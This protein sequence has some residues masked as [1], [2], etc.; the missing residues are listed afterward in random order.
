MNEYEQLASNLNN[1]AKTNVATGTE[2][3]TIAARRGL[4]D[5]NQGIRLH[6]MDR[7][8]L[9]K[10]LMDL[11]QSQQD[12]K[13]QKA[14]PYDYFGAALGAGGSIA[15]GLMARDKAKAQQDQLDS[16]FSRFGGY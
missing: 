15:S 7:Q 11:F 10:Q 5:A 8:D 6:G 12:E 2:P 3:L 1:V 4:A 16:I 13:N 9:F 14:S